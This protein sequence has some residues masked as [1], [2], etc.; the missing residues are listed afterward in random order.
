M[1]FAG[2]VPSPPPSPT[3]PN[4]GRY[5]YQNDNTAPPEESE[6]G[7]LTSDLNVRRGKEMETLVATGK[8]AIIY[9]EVDQPTPT[10]TLVGQKAIERHRV[11][12][13]ALVELH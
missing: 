8:F 4:Y 6:L 3:A 13:R 5:R 11:F 12:I 10:A 1:G 9:A 7:T 2:P